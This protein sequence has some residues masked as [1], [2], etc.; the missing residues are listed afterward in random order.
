MPKPHKGWAAKR[1]CKRQLAGLATL[2][3]KRPKLLKKAQSCQEYRV[4][5]KKTLK[6]E[7]PA[8]KTQIIRPAKVEKSSCEVFA[9]RA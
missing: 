1:P 7:K 2:A 3:P 6:V 4:S 8:Q 9:K 5:R